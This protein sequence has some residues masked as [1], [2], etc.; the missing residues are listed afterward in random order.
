MSKRS[1]LITAALTTIGTLLIAACGGAGQQPAA[2][3][4]AQAQPAAAEPTAASGVTSAPFSRC[5]SDDG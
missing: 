2:E 3:T 4:A 1:V 5:P